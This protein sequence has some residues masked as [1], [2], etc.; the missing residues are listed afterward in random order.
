MMTADRDDELVQRLRLAARAND[1]PPA[2]VLEAARAAL[3]WRTLD[4]D[5]AALIADSA[6]ELAPAGVRS[7]G[8]LRLLSF[9]TDSYAVDVEVE[10]SGADR[11]LTG[12]IDPPGP[13]W[14]VA[15]H[16]QGTITAT[17]D[18]GG[19]FI[20]VVP[21]GPVRLRFESDEGSAVVTDWV[22]V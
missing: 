7:V 5:L 2:W 13:G 18:R 17:V 6:D 8:T 16:A 15:A 21:A 19:R 12:T 11:R 10:D 9:E 14:L 20:V 22:L 4:A 3:G 1:A